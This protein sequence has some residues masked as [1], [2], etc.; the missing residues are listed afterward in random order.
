MI[1]LDGLKDW[2]TTVPFLVA[3]T[4]G[5]IINEPQSF[6]PAVVLAAK[7]LASLGLALGGINAIGSKKD[8]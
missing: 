7:Y 3:A 8:K 1:N 4:A 6:P 2:K 5:F